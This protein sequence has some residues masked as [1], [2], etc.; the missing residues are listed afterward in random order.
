MGGVG[1]GWGWRWV[2]VG[3]RGGGPTNTSWRRLHWMSCS[4]AGRSDSSSVA[5][6]YRSRADSSSGEQEG[7]AGKGFLSAGSL[8]AAFRPSSP[9]CGLQSHF[10]QSVM[11]C[12]LSCCVNVVEERWLWLVSDVH[13]AVMFCRKRWGALS[14]VPMLHAMAQL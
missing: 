1:G 4:S 6:L 2:G 8:L 11:D 5:A 10:T 3:T 13:T 14:V 12:L 9:P 7:T